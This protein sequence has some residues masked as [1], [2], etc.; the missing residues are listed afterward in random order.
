MTTRCGRGRFLGRLMRIMPRGIRLVRRRSFFRMV[1]LTMDGWLRVAAGGGRIRM[2]LLR[3]RR[4][5]GV[6]RAGGG[7]DR[8]AL[9]ALCRPEAYTT[10]AAGLGWLG[11]FLFLL[12][13]RL[14]V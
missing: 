14:P 1:R 5:A 10:K 4:R 9:L 8:R 7:V 2:L 13:R 11:A 3:G 6:E 12:R